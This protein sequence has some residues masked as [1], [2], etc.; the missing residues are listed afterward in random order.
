MA[1]LQSAAPWI[2]HHVSRDH[3]WHGRADLGNTSH[4]VP[5]LSKPLLRDRDLSTSLSGQGFSTSV[6]TDRFQAL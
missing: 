6:I 5:V 2:V 3:P 4:C 1:P